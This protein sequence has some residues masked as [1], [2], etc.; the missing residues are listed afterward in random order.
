MW[1]TFAPTVF[2]QQFGA[3][4]AKLL[5]FLEPLLPL[6]TRWQS[7]NK[8]NTNNVNSNWKTK[9]QKRETVGG[10]GETI[11]LEVKLTLDICI[12]NVTKKLLRPAITSSFSLQNADFSQDS[13]C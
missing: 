8:Y 13:N 6:R 5:H 10:V 11:K 12:M 1:S 9:A 3:V 2:S 7:P 4:L